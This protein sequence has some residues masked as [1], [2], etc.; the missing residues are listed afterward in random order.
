MPEECKFK[1]HSR[2]GLYILIILILFTTC[3]T[4][5]FVYK[6]HENLDKR[7]K[8]IEQKLGIEDGLHDM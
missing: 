8:K 6:R 7:L 4:N 5:Y 2:T 1:R 3:D